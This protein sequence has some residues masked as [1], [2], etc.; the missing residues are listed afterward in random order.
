MNS[1]WQERSLPRRWTVAAQWGC[2]VW[3]SQLLTSSLGH[4]RPCDASTLHKEG[5][6][7]RRTTLAKETKGVGGGG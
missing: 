6:R 4:R 3:G 1:C 2:E 7:K 5:G